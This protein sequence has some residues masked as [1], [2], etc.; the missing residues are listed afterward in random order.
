VSQWSNALSMVSVRAARDTEYSVDEL[1][2]PLTG[3]YGEEAGS[4]FYWI[5]P[6]NLDESRTLLLRHM[7]DAS[8]LSTPPRT[9][10]NE[11]LGSQGR[12]ASFSSQGSSF[13]HRILF[14]N[15]RRF[16]KDTTSSRPTRIALNVHWSPDPDAAI[17]I[18]RPFPTSVGGTILSVKCKDLPLAL[19]REFPVRKR[20]NE[21]EAARNYLTEHRD[22][23]PLAEYSTARS[24]YIGITN[25]ADVANWATL[26]TSIVV[27]SPDLSR[28][29]D[30]EQ[31]S[32]TSNAFPYSVL[33]IRWE[34]ASSP[35]VVRV[36]DESHLVERVQDFTLEDMAIHTV[37]KELPKPTWHSLLGKD[38]RKVPVLARKFRLGVGLGRVLIRTQLGSFF[39]FP[40]FVDLDRFVSVPAVPP[41]VATDAHDLGDGMEPAGMEPDQVLSCVR[42][43]RISSCSS[44]SCSD[45]ISARSASTFL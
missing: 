11:S 2:E 23:K 8:A 25:S 28:L 7:R 1:D 37:Q 15:A 5:H 12:Y 35:D 38:I 9:S 24:R 14:D 13:V 10:S 26:D 21:V 19:Q 45:L 33:H 22:V 40:L 31:H 20:S 16:I 6:D 36:F 27:A 42:R 29:G 34:F 39:R 18:A 17:S 44:F 32:R 41:L 3:P 43:D 30:P 4:A